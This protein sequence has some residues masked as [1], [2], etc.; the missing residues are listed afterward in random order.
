MSKLNQEELLE[1][2]DHFKEVYLEVCRIAK[3][4]KILTPHVKQTFKQI[5]EMI[6]SDAW[7]KLELALER[8][9]RLKAQIVD[10]K[11]ALSK[12]P[13][14]P[15]VTE[16]WIEEKAREI[17]HEIHKNLVYGRDYE[18]R[19]KVTEDFIRSLIKELK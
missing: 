12:I 1:E 9:E 7:R 3:T 8:N 15:E 14:K 19:V 18:N 4:E 11:Y 2:L 17:L 13:E 10:Y 16:K 5:K 6:Q